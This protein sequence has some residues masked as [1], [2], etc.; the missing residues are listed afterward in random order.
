VNVLEPGRALVVEVREGP[1][2]QCGGI[3]PRRVEPA[4]AK[5]DEPSR[6][7]GDRVALFV[8][9]AREREGL[10]GGRRGVTEP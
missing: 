5:L 4:V 8:G 9:R 3:E 7:L 1:L 10:E 2:L 6:R